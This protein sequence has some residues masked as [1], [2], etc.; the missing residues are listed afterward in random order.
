[1]AFK[2][3]EQ[4]RCSQYSD[5]SYGNN[6]LFLFSPR[7]SSA[8]NDLTIIA[9]DGGGWEHVS[10]SKK[11]ECP[12]WDE[13]CFVKKLFWSDPEDFAVQFHPPE[14]QYVNNHPYCLHLWRPGDGQ[15]RFPEVWM[16]G[17]K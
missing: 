7:P 9:S 3:P 10:V 15:M 4:H 11:Y 17:I 13:M 2:V 5:A 1:M 6:G 14:S 12:T 8:R 16:V